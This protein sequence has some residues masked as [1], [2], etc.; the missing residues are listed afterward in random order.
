LVFTIKQPVLT[1]GTVTGYVLSDPATLSVSVTDPDGATNA[2]VYGT[3]PELTRVEVGVFQLTISVPQA[4][5]W[6]VAITATAP[7]V[8]AE[9]T[10]QVG[11]S[12]DWDVVPPL[13][14]YV[15][16]RGEPATAY[17][18]MALDQAQLL[19]QMAAGPKNAGERPENPT[20][21]RIYKFGIFAMAEALE[22]SRGTR[23]LAL[24][25]FR[26]E[27]IGSY[28]YEKARQD[29]RRGIPTGI[30]WFDM[31]VDHFT[32]KCPLIGSMYNSITMFDYEDGLR[33]LDQNGRDRILGPA[34]VPSMYL[35]EYRLMKVYGFQFG[36]D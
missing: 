14:D 35:D 15:M 28:R 10:F 20:D 22:N 25:P 21:E 34:E 17:S 6:D 4:G 18:T 13:S 7:D 8:Y 23:S 5:E 12:Q 30:M 27:E 1:A 24:S 33:S 16:F 31:A 19:L 36:V 26:V 32:A 11:E 9:Q 29:V 3:D 2:Y